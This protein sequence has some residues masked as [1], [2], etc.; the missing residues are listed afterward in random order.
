MTS[1]AIGEPDLP[2]GLRR[3]TLG[4]LAWLSG[5]RLLQHLAVVGAVAVLARLLTPADFGLLAM[6]AVFTGFAAVFVDLGLS[7]ALVQRREIGERHLSTAFWLNVGTA[8]VL[9]ALLCVLAPLLAAVYDESEVIPI[10]LVLALA[11]PLSAL[12]AV[13]IA[14]AERTMQFRRLSVVESSALAVSYGAAIAGA[15]AGLGVWALVLQP[16]VLAAVRSSALWLSSSWRPSRLFD[17]G[18]ARDLLGYGGHLAGFN[19]VTY[20][21]R[22]F[23]QFA[24]GAASGAGE[25]GLYSRSF[26]LVLF[27]LSQ[28]TLVSG[29]V[30]FPALSRI[31]DS[32]ERIR[33]AYLRALSLIAF[34][35]VPL[36]VILFVAAVPLIQVVL[37]SQWSDA[38]PIF[39]VLCI[40][41][42]LQSIA[43]TGGWL[44][45]TRGRTDWMFRWSLVSVAVTVIA[46]AIGVH[47]GALGVAVAYA[48]RTVIL[49]P[50]TLAIPGSLV[51]VTL[52]DIGRVLYGIALVAAA[53]GVALFGIDAVITG[54]PAWLRLSID[55]AAGCALYAAFAAAFRLAALG[56]ARALLAARHA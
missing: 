39:R 26:Q 14:L 36:I 24:V 18:A 53:A 50:P 8:V 7:A 45:R 31:A 10:T 37:G 16:V 17:A 19:A 32:A 5:G 56:E 27:P 9:A 51:G 55:L 42:V 6:P 48:I 41:G 21:T 23:D 49:A 34:V 38:V 28:V 54:A 20:W 4:G 40:V 46:V 11:F 13:Q 30:M 12:A 47:W 44:Y 33:A 25:L 29:C 1:T 15:V 2:G 3:S 35:T 52:L 43:A 22:S